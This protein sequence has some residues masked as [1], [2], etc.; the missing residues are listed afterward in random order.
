MSTAIVKPE[1][2][3]ISG[4]QVAR[5]ARAQAFANKAVGAVRTFITDHIDELVQ[6]RQDFWDIRKDKSKLICGVHG[7]EDYIEGVL[8]FSASYIRSLLPKGDNPA[9]IHDGSKQR[10][11]N[12]RVTLPKP[13]QPMSKPSFA[14]ASSPI[15]ESDA[16]SREDT[17]R[18]ILSWTLSCLKGFSLIKK[19]LIVEDV[20]AKLRDDLAFDER[21]KKPEVE[22]SL[23]VK[24]GSEPDTD[25]EPPASEPPKRKKA[26]A[27][28]PTSGDLSGT[29]NAPPSN[30]IV[31]LPPPS[32]G[33]HDADHMRSV[34]S[35]VPLRSR[36]TNFPVNPENPIFPDLVLE[37]C[38]REDLRYKS[39][40]DEHY[41]KNKGAIGQ[42]VHFIVWYKKKIAG[43]I[44]G[45][46]A[47]YR[48]ACR[49]NFFKITKE[50][51][52]KFMTGII[53]NSVFRMEYRS[54]K[55]MIAKNGKDV[56]EESVATQVLA[57]WRKVV[58]FVWFHLYAAIPGGFETFV[59]ETETRKGSIYKG[60][61]WEYVGR[62]VGASKS[63]KGLTNAPVRENVEPKLVY[64]K[65]SDDYSYFAECGDPR[66]HSSGYKPSWEGKTPE[67]KQRRKTV[68]EQRM[69]LMGKVFYIHNSHRFNSV[70][71]TSLQ[72]VLPVAALDRDCSMI[73]VRG[74]LP[75]KRTEQLVQQ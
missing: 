47:A 30:G 36:E 19:R 33:I 45:G 68:A 32:D 63:R 67:E 72:N 9:S 17:S 58:P 54:D 13:N 62:T 69:H 27:T 2:L 35:V 51:R 48:V 52:K 53:N 75:E 73:S 18:R 22:A 71:F 5:E 7:F 16:W 44:S 64:V 40:R 3:K 60:D 49:D 1:P 10:K 66:F 37:F 14:I 25:T 70:C 65:K 61:N 43:I 11:A 39:I 24:S 34:E 56:P 28:L 41:V 4:S 42:Q 6:I 8:H 15:D 23:S 59:G 20:I 55:R 74:A 29:K 38:S 31:A 21:T 26:R 46:S 57:L 50:N 12:A